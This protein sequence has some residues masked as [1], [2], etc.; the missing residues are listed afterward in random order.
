M[1]VARLLHR[2]IKK[3]SAGNRAPLVFD[4]LSRFSKYTEAIGCAV[5]FLL[6][7]IAG[8]DLFLLF[9]KAFHLS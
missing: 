9:Y 5:I 6:R 2:C 7:S 8:S 1:F 3:R 4:H